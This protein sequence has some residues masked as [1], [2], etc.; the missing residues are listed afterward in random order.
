MR[1]RML[2]FLYRRRL[3]AH[4]AQELLAGLGVAI[5]VA[6]LFAVTVADGSIAGSASEVVHAVIGPANLQ[7]RARGSGGF[8]EGVLAHVEA[9]P[10]VEQAAPLLEQT[11]NVVGPNGHRATVQIA[12]AEL[13]LGLL[14]GLAHTIPLAAFS[15]NGI[16]LSDHTAGSI[17]VSPLGVSATG[18]PTHPGT[19][20]GARQHV[21]L[22]LRGRVTAL[23]VTAVLDKRTFGAL[24]S[25]PVAVMALAR[26]Q[27]LAGLQRRITRILVQSKPGH[28]AEV[29]T[30][31]D[32]LAGPG[33]AVGPAD[34]DIALLHQALRPSDQSSEFF[35]AICALLGFLFAFNAILL[36]VPERRHAIADLRLLGARGAQVAQMVIFQALCLGLAASL[37]GLVVGYALAV[38]PFHQSPAYLAEA[39]TL[40]TST[41]IGTWPLVLALGGGIL[42]TCLASTLTLL[43]L[44]GGR[45]LEAT[46][47]TDG[48]SADALGRAVQLRLA[49]AAAGVLVLSSATFELWSSLSLAALTALALATVLLVPLALGLVLRAARALAARRQELTLLPVALISLRGSTLRSL[50]LAT[51]GAVALF[52]SGALGG[53]RADLLQG[54]RAFS[55]SYSADANIWVNPPGAYQATTALQPG[56]D[57]ARIARVPGVSAVRSFFGGYLDFDGRRV[58]VIAR[59]PGAAREVLRSQIVAGNAAAASAALAAGG[60]IAVS[61]QIAAEHHVGVGD[62]LTLPTPTG[63]VRFRIAATTT[64]LS[65]NPGAILMSAADYQ[66][67]WATS[68]PSAFGVQ[69][70]PG[71]DATRVR[72]EIVRA[73]GPASGLEVST[74]PVRAAEID[75]LAG[76]GLSRLGEIST[77]LTI[78]AI[79]ALATAL[80]S[81]IWQRRTTLAEL[82]LTGVT[83]ARLRRML[84]LE[85]MLL[86]GAGCVTGA[87]VGLYGQ[88][89]IDGYLRDVTGFPIVTLTA[90]LRPLELLALV[91][92]VVLALVAG[93]GFFAARVSPTL[94]L[95]E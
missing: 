94:A 72:G 45:T 67:Y 2:V 63:N 26:L 35:A 17:G 31:L 6:L 9:L 44:R 3:R 77:L 11:A 7:L 34:E 60:Q 5:A 71:A 32:A 65:W 76:A 51:T 69:L 16:G 37:V 66:R 25:A 19:R 89:V 21:A 83:P 49:L 57:V 78:A 27:A 84:L 24:A 53:A 70:A 28:E 80:A 38:G 86:L 74:A 13:S 95:E 90:G 18:V 12:G 1:P 55:R 64:N 58:W 39:F 23:P 75:A 29:R 4:L 59:P 93:P 40:G 87:L 73:L 10:G 82:R 91:I 68:A 41:V 56:D 62:S 88:V 42:A 79:L 36:T 14:D 43:D 46:P 85:S 22:E 15:S 20:S 50:A 92:V 8:D 81:A 30:E 48:V 54:I 47:A 33:L 61:R 52:G